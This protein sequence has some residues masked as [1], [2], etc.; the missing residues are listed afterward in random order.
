MIKIKILGCG[1]SNGVPEVGCLCSVCLSNEPRNNRTRSSL[2]LSNG[3]KKLLIDASPDFRAQALKNGLQRIDAILLT[4]NHADHIS[5]LDDLK[6]FCLRTAEIN[7]IPVYVPEQYYK[8]LVLRY[9]YIFEDKV[10]S[11]NTWRAFLELRTFKIGSV[12]EIPE[13]DLKVQ[14]LEQQHGNIVSAGFRLGDFAYSVDFNTIEDAVLHKLKGIKCWIVDLLRYYWSPSHLS[15]DSLLYFHEVVKPE[16]TILTHM[17]HNVCYHE[18][19]H[20]KEMNIEPA[21]DGMSIA[22]T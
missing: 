1:G 5:G 16:R 3:D 19:Q 10:R 14:S 20:L 8:D 4:H 12:V 21:Y 2:L 11:H 17:S 7:K 13:V 22:L 18:I 15:I 6:P 9:P